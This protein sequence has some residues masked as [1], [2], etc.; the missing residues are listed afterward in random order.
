MAA[1]LQQPS[2]RQVPVLAGRHAVLEPLQAT[3]VDGLRMALDGSGLERLWYANVPAPDRVAGY[4][5]R[6]LEAQAQ[7]HAL[8]FVVRD[9]TGSIVGST[10]FYALAPEVPRLNIGHTWYAPRVQRTGVNTECKLLLLGHAFDV[11]D[12]ASVGFETSW[13]NHASRMAIARLGARQDGV[14]RNHMRHADGTLRDTVVFS[15]TTAEWPAVRS[16]LRFRLDA[17]T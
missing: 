5:E 12:C 9:S 14:L 10:R 1:H 11:L 3:H 4:V 17:N 15:I 2:W 13:H 6:A 16:H 7:G 8:P